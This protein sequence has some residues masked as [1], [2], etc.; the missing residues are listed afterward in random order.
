MIMMLK[1]NIMKRFF[2]PFILL[3]S[4]H[5]LHSIADDAAFRMLILHTNDVDSMIEQFN[6]D[7]EEC[8]QEQAD[9]GECFGGYARLK[10]A[11]KY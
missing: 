4:H 6:N 3:V 9:A 5:G 11:V 10:T 2:L 7:G 8:T 1:Y